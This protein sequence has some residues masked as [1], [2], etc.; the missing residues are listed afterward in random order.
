MRASSTSTGQPAPLSYD[1]GHARMA[2]K[3]YWAA[4]EDM[5]MYS[6][7]RPATTGM[8]EPHWHPVT[9]ELGY[10]HKGHA[11]MRVLAPDGTS[12]TTSSSRGEAYFIPRAYPHHIE[13]LGDDGFHFLIFFDQP[14]PGRHRLPRDRFRV[15][16]GGLSRRVRGAGAR[17]A[18]VPVHP[19]RPAHRRPH[20]PPRSQLADATRLEKRVVDQWTMRRAHSRGRRQRSDRRPC[21]RGAARARAQGDHGGAHRATGRRPPARPQPPPRPTIFGGCSRATT[22]SSTPPAPTSN[23]PLPRPIYPRFRQ[24]L[25]DPVVRLFTAARDE[26]LTRGVLMGSYYTYFD[27][28]RPQWR[29]PDRHSY[30]RCR[31]EQA[32]EARRRADGPA[33]G[34]ARVALRVRP[35][36]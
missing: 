8:R 25:V 2:R 3:Q 21:H 19:G 6:L 13:P 33:G 27:R 15:L 1:Y 23:A 32:A 22:V 35:G 10:V 36:R 20:Q 17:A 34:R 28:L 16:P 31:V 24:D 29:L 5:S 9:A 30:I 11:R 12:T 14:M 7:R 26:G 18:G 4:L